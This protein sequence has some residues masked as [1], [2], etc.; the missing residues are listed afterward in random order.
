MGVDSP[1][2]ASPLPG[3]M[4]PHAERNTMR[5]IVKALIL[6]ISASFSEDLHTK[7]NVPLYFIMNSI[8]QVA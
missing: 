5:V 7:Q 4:G 8:A 3:M 6:F 2:V 1:G